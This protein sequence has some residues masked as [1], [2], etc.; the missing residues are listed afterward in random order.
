MVSTLF[1]SP[2]IML[3][4]LVRLHFSVNAFSPSSGILTLATRLLQ[5]LNLSSPTMV[6][7]K[8]E[9][10]TPLFIGSCQLG[11]SKKLPFSALTTISTKPLQLVCTDVW[12]PAPIPSISGFRYYVLFVDD[13][14]RYSW[15]YPLSN[16]SDVYDVFISFKTKVENLLEHRIKILRSDGGGVSSPVL[17]LRNS[18]QSMA[19]PIRYLALTH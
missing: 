3:I 19:S 13:F 8:M 11:K 9:H 18:S 12:G 16:K 5:H 7:L 14:S 17:S 2:Q 6:F 10:L 4:K 15:L 1:I